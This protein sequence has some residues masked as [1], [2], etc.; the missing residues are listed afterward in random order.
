MSSFHTL[1][2]LLLQKGTTLEKS[3][4]FRQK[5]LGIWNEISWGNYLK[6]V[7]S[8]S[9]GL[10]SEFGFQKGDKLAIIADNRPHWAY[11]QLAA[12]SLGGIAVGIYQESSPEQLVFSI[13]Y[14]EA[15]VVVAE[16]QEQV[17]KLL[18][19]EE[20]LP[21][22]EAIVYFNDKGMR[23]Y[24]NKKLVY[25][26]QLQSKGLEFLHLNES[27]FK[28]KV[29]QVSGQ[30]TAIISFTAG[31][32]A[33]P[34]GVMLSHSNLISAAH[35]LCEVD[36]VLENDDILSFLPLAWIGEQVMTITMSLYKNVTIN[37]PEEPTTV[38][39][40]LREIGPHSL[41]ALPRTYENIISRFKLRI[42]GA[43]WLKKKVYQFFKPYGDKIAAAKCKNEKLTMSQK[44]FYW[45][46]DFL[47]FSA[48]RDHLGLARIRFAYSS[49]GALSSEA[50]EFFQSIGVNV[51]QCY[52]ATE[53]AGISFIQRDNNVKQGSLGTP[54]PNTEVKVSE[55]GE[56]CVKGPSVFQGYYK[57]E[58]E[59]DS[60]E[61][62]WLR[63]GDRGFLEPDGNLYLHDAIH[64]I[65]TLQSGEEVTP[66][67]MENKLKTSRYIKE[68]VI[69]GKEK[70]YLVSLINID[71]ENVG[72][73]A[74]K[75]QITYT[76][77]ADLS[78]KKEVISLIEKE[79]AHLLKEIPDNLRIKKFVILHKELD[80]DDEELT[81]TQ[82][83]RRSFLEEKYKLLFECFYSDHSKLRW[84]SEAEGETDLQIINLAESQE[85]A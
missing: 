26:P 19:V 22:V 57:E 30:D 2:E 3:I 71:M 8:L 66:T 4:A 31:S 45:L 50:I 6:E 79:V 62:G 76:T 51:K 21:L 11:A 56:I 48:I 5:K 40:D 49:G 67:Q 38:L 63:L 82:K 59:A 25:M 36:K 32:S 70:P 69:Y 27:Y 73:W 9:L 41:F 61:G 20:Q 28:E 84:E 81:R 23:R 68:A 60:I 83:V 64:N 18:E 14:C 1:P 46:G 77:Y 39:N 34:K 16:D 7:E 72:R 29:S 12:Q 13:N 47:V 80:A 65:F 53:S 37:F 85:V 10:V 17:D 24:T 42:D 74:E 55:V 35:N 15:R 75:N 43:S 78:M 52:G 33:K 58:R 44:M 54:V